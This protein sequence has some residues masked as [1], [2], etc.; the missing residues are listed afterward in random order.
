VLEGKVTESRG[1]DQRQEAQ[2]AR[3]ERVW[4]E[5]RPRISLLVARLAGD[6][7]GAEDLTQE[8]ALRAFQGFAAFRGEARVYT[9]L[10]R[11]AVNV[12]NRHRERRRAEAIPLDAP[13]AVVL[14][15]DETSDPE[16][17]ALGADLRVRVWSALE[18]LPDELRTALILQL[19][20]GLKYR[21]VAAVL[22][23]PIGTVKSR[24]HNAVQRLKE[25]LSDAV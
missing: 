14:T 19:Y 9:W 25:D 10:Y 13:E 21:E 22:D 6:P 2:R 1:E 17:A 20:Q 11:I 5:H 12:V 23:I 4:Q 8:V 18:R 24:L 16:A 7:Q 3:F 15:A